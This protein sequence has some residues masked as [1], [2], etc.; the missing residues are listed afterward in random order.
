[1]KK[2]GTGALVLVIMS[3]EGVVHDL[4]NCRF[5]VNMLSTAWNVSPFTLSWEGVLSL[6]VHLVTLLVVEPATKPTCVKV[7]M[8]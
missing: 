5:Y 3:H 1:M 2:A 8:V 4:T 7:Y 6:I